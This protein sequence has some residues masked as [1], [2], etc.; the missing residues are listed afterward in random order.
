[1][2]NK[3]KMKNPKGKI[4]DALPKALKSALD[5]PRLRDLTFEDLSVCRKQL[6][7]AFDQD[8]VDFL[9]TACQLCCKWLR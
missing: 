5:K 4:I 7:K 6:E 2:P 1:M 3:K 8:P 9:H